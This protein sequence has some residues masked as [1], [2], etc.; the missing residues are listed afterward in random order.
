MAKK[1]KQRKGDQ[2]GN[3]DEATR[4]IIAEAT[5]ISISQQLQK[6]HESKDE[7]I[8]KFLI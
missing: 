3:M 8:N 6:F 7:G 2:N 4:L 5:T 1:K